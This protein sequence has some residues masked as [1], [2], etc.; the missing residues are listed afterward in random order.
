[1]GQ[2]LNVTAGRTEWATMRA[3]VQT[4]DDDVDNGRSVIQVGPATHLGAGDL[5][6][7]LRA[8]RGRRLVIDNSA[9]F[10]GIDANAQDG[11][12]GNVTANNYTLPGQ[13]G[14]E[15][16]QQALTVFHPDSELSI[17]LDPKQLNP[18]GEPKTRWIRVALDSHDSGHYDAMVLAQV[19]SENG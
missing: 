11:A 1:M 2:V 16:E 10:S 8:N 18:I 17:A 5:V 15:S 14:V 3:L 9:R 19:I 12:L 6:E 13:Y 7:L 4:V